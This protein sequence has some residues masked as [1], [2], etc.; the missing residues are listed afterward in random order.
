M[1]RPREIKDAIRVSTVLSKAQAN[2]VK[3]MARQMSTREG[4]TITASEA[5][6]M[7]IETL[8]PLPKSQPTL[9]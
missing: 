5:I 6:R 1:A 2:H 4:R 7:A 8:Y 9:F 3:H